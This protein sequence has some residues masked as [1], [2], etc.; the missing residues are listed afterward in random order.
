[1]RYEKP[2][3]ASAMANMHKKGCSVP[4]SF[5]NSKSMEKSKAVHYPHVIRAN[6]GVQNKKGMVLQETKTRLLLLLVI[7]LQGLTPKGL[8]VY[9]EQ[10]QR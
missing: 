1:V 5:P 2:T 6:N 7:W 9:Y 4:Y 3:F 8:A 10:K